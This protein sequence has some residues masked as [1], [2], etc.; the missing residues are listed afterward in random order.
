MKSY[1]KK[2]MA[3]GAS[4]LMLSNLAA[5]GNT[6]T[7]SSDPA[8]VDESGRQ[9]V[10]VGVMAPLSG[11]MSRFGEVYKASIEAAMKDIEA[12]GLLKN[13]TLE[14]EFIDDK[15]STDGAPT[16]ATYALD[17]YNCDVAIGHMLTTMILVSGQYFEDAEVPLLGIVSGPASVAQG[18]DYLSIETGTDLSQADTLIEYLVKEKN[19]SKIGLI[20]VNTEGGMSA[21]D[22]IEEVLKSEYNLEL[23]TR[24]AMTNEDMDFT[25][26]VLKMKEAG[27]ETVI[28]WGL[29]QANAN[30]CMSQIEQ[31][32][33]PVPEEVF[34]A[35][36][37]N[38]AQNQM[39]ETFS[40]E[41]VV[42]IVF[43]VGYI[44]DESNPQ[45]A[46]FIESFKAA[47]PLGQDPADVPARV[48]DAV[49]HIAYALNDLGEY[50]VN[51]DDFS[52]KLN[53][54]LRNAKFTGV[55]GEFDFTVTNDGVGLN[56]MNV[57]QW[58]EEY[59]QTK[60]YP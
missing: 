32:W 56:Q 27:V 12:D 58:E 50:D 38:L 17:Q 25:P 29:N 7:A 45:I 49:Y 39:L 6:G 52:I 11:D 1:L 21:A 15:G 57:G 26:Q 44:P 2:M 20:H 9:V 59:K 36:G 53:E 18:W 14:F 34:F 28:F 47:D 37:T 24:D 48:Y 33:A 40:E 10:K 5:C 30:V 19:F 3:L 13:Y 35:G 51:A 46:R 54:A 23:T 42:G 16:A 22:R 31:L 41:D 4:C 60:I 8:P 55:Q 43:P